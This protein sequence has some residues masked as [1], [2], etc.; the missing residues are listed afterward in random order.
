VIARGRPR[1]PALPAAQG[2]YTAVAGTITAAPGV[3]SPG[4]CGIA[5]GPATEG[6]E[7]PVIPCGERLYLAYRGTTVLASVVAH[8]PTP[9]GREFD[10][11]PE[12]AHALGLFGVHQIH[13]SYAAAAP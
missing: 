12:L 3:G 1:P 4:G 9:A 10:L 5:V 13:W 8:E 6:I 11:T 7:N 2:S